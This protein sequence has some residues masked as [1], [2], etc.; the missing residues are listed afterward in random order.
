M[1]S[2]ITFG[3]DKDKIVNEYERVIVGSEE[4]DTL[5]DLFSQLDL[6]FS[7]ELIQFDI[8]GAGT[9]KD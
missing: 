5:E 9:S 2:Y 4:A 8:Q 7:G 6:Y 1:V 3:N